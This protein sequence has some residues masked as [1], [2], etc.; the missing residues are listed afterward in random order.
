MYVVAQKCKI[1]TSSEVIVLHWKN[2]QPYSFTWTS[3]ELI[4]SPILTTKGQS[5]STP[6]SF[7]LFPPPIFQIWPCHIPSLGLV[8]LFITLA[9]KYKIFL[10]FFSPWPSFWHGRT[11]RNIGAHRGVWLPELTWGI[12]ME[13]KNNLEGETRKG[14]AKEAK[15]ALPVS[16]NHAQIAITK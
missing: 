7:S 10:N 5:C 16:W 4:N 13:K 2:R 15:L 3:P 6:A 8:L 9:E 1:F 14:P 11:V 12:C